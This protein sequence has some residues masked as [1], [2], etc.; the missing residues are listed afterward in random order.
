MFQR[1]GVL[2]ALASALIAQNGTGRI[3]GVVTDPSGAVVRSAKITVRETGSGLTKVMA[4]DQTGAWAA[5]ALPAGRYVVLASAPGFADAQR[6]GVFLST[7][8]NV[9]VDLNLA[10]AA[11]TNSVTV[12][13]LTGEDRDALAPEL[14]KTNDT[15]GLA[16]DFS[17]I[18]LFND[19][20]LS[21]I[22]AIHGLADERVAV[23]VDG[24]EIGSA[25]VMHMN[26]PLSYFDPSQTGNLDVIAGI[27]PVSRGG[28]SIGGTVAVD[29]APP[30]FSAR[31]T[32]Q[33]HG[34]IEAFHRTNGVA[35]GGSASL[36]F[37]TR[38]FQIN[39]TGSYV[40]AN[41]YKDGSGL[42]VAST[43]YEAQNNALQ[44]SARAG[45]NLFTIGIG[46]QYI[47]QQG[48]PN[49]FLDMTGNQAKFANFHY[50]GRFSWFSKE[51]TLEGRLYYE[52][53]RHSMDILRDKVPGVEMPMFTRG[54]N[55]GYM[56]GAEIPLSARDTLRI[57]HE[58]RRFTL[59]D[60]WTP[61]TSVIGTLG[62]NTLL[63]VNNGRRNRF[64]TWAE[65]EARRAKRWT[66]LL[67]IRSDI[68]LM[69]T[70]N[71]QGYNSSPAATGDAAYYADATEFNSVSHARQDYNFDLTALARFDAAPFLSLEAGYARKTRSPSIY[72]RYLWVKRSFF[73]ADMEGWFGDL[74][75]YTGNLDLKP[76][77]AHTVSGTLSLHDSGSK[78]W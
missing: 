46:Y 7:G 18:D 76:E 40:N 51:V 38:N 35:N 39:Y 22:P 20:G 43:F 14:M 63:N 71:V 19:G 25:C 49:A 17:G 37:T 13:G 54:G 36:A 75:G 50:R 44:A 77:V 57:G 11:Q 70:G 21:G 12:T 66:T 16:S 61:T 78:G 9:T 48:F 42:L 4:T 73:S 64:G 29:T 60:W 53:T 33:I 31:S 28:D 15:A 1:I 47:P 6:T 67:G 27:T 56:V 3:T 58:F 34:N 32:P 59:N 62:P 8:A 45:N 68:V 52:N 65:W 2:A 69:D 30:E 41:D 74:N 10:P 72:E 5:P 24:M 23:R 26:P 55:A